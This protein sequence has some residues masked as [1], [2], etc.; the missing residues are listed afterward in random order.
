MKDKLD[1][2]GLFGGSFDPI[3]SGHL[4]L[5]NKALEILDLDRL[6]FIPTNHSP[7]KAN[8]P[9]HS[10]ELRLSMIEACIKNEKKFFL[11]DYEIFKK[12]KAYT[13]DTIEHYRQ[14]YPTSKLYYLMGY[15]SWQSLY[16]WKGFPEFTLNLSFLVFN[17]D[18]Q[19]QIDN[20]YDLDV[21]FVK[22]FD[23]P[24]SSS[25]IKSIK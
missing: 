6:D 15:D 12:E 23:Y 9:Q 5:A 13:K 7:L 25:L 24:M 8:K 14:N 18:S 20:K 2:L 1:K 10:P 19:L 16:L 17:R 22:D 3:H 4:A 11:C 21:I